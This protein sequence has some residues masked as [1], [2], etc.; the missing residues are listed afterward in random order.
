MSRFLAPLALA[1]S[2]FAQGPS[3]V[4]TSVSFNGSTAP[5]VS[6]LGAETVCR[7]DGEAGLP[8][9][10]YFALDAGPTTIGTVTFPIGITG[11][12]EIANYAPM[13]PEGFRLPVLMPQNPSFVGLTVHSLGLLVDPAHPTGARVSNPVSVM[14][15]SF[16][17]DAGPDAASVIGKSVTLDGSNNRDANGNVPAGITYAWSLLSAPTG[18]TATLA[19]ADTAFPVIT[20]DV[21]GAYVVG[22]VTGGSAPGTDSMTLDAYNLSYT[23]PVNGSFG[24]GS[25]TPTGSV[26]G[27]AGATYRVGTS[28]VTPSGTGSFTAPAVSTP[29]GVLAAPVSVAITGPSGQKLAATST[30]LVGAGQPIANPALPAAGVRANGVSL[31]PLE[32]LV[33][34]A[35]GSIDFS[36]IIGLLPNIPILTI[37]GIFGT[38]FLSVTADPQT[39]TYDPAVDLDFYPGANGAIGIS[40]TFTN[41]V[42]TTNLSGL[43]FNAPYNEV[44]T[45][46]AT[47]AVVSGN[48]VLVPSATGAQLQVQGATCVLN[49]FTFSVTGALGSLTQVAT[50]QNTLKTAIQAALATS[51]QLLPPLV[52]PLLNQYNSFT[53]D[54]SAA[55][56]PLTL[57][58]PL[59]SLYYDALGLTVGFGLNFQP[60]AGAVVTNTVTQ[61]RT[62]PGTVP[63]FGATTPV[64]GNTYTGGLALNDDTLNA[65]FATFTN[66]GVLDI[67]LSG[68]LGMGTTAVALNAG[69]LDAA[70][71]TSGFEAF[72]P[73]TPVSVR[74]RQTTA[75]S[76]ALAAGNPA[77]GTFVLG[78][79]IVTFSAVVD[80]DE[81][82]I[83]TSALTANVGIQ[84]AVDPV[85]G[86]LA[87]TPGTVNSVLSVETNFPGRDA[88]PYAGA[89]AS[90]LSVGVTQILNTIG[91]IPLAGIGG[92]TG[93]ISVIGDNLT[94]FF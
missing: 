89:L 32:P 56:V 62:T 6:Y 71:P 19:F 68:T 26:V 57:G 53:F 10:W 38:T 52:N 60:A 44:A 16:A 74:F 91:T 43:L 14:F 42:I 47:S 78:N 86:T 72:D 82:P 9:L 24:S 21:A 41:V 63:V 18:S 94:I 66:L 45:I 77:T 27:P 12:V 2:L 92:T 17:T 73:T 8:A 48:M 1:A 22:L 31:D 59:Y 83:L 84:F 93:E 5:V 7:F 11:I 33:E 49:G 67:N 20:P 54:L 75:P 34:Q 81:R 61:F 40:L 70:F 25:F 50:I 85:T 46:N 80:G 39:F 88:S 28:N 65:I 4:P 58:F 35:L 13:L 64:L 51:L 87:V 30:R 3:Q 79:A 36:S 55:G 15:D 23:T 29:T 37:P 90:A 69:A 76:F